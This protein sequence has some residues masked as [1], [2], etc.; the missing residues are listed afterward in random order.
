MATANPAAEALELMSRNV[1]ASRCPIA[2][3][4]AQTCTVFLNPPCACNPCQTGGMISNQPYDILKV[5][6]RPQTRCCPHH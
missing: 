6:A 2:P 4:V 5:I 3:Q 1:E